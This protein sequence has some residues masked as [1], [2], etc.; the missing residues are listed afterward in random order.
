MRTKFVLTLFLLSIFLNPVLAATT[1]VNNTTKWAGTIPNQAKEPKSWVQLLDQLEE[2]KM[3]FSLLAAASRMLVLFNEL[4]VK[5]KAY[6]SI[7]SIIDMG[8]PFPL[9]NLFLSGDLSSTSDLDFNNSYSLYKSILNKDRGMSKWAQNYLDSITKKEE[10]PKYQFYLAIDLLSQK[11]YQEADEKLK[12][13]LK[14]DYE[15][16]NFSFVKK[17]TRTLARSY[18]DQE[19]YAESY[20]I[21][22]NYLL[23]LNPILPN[24]W[25]EAAWNLYYLKKYQ[26]ALGMVYNL[27]STSSLRN[28]MNL[29]KYTLRALIYRN[30]CAVQNAE[31]LIDTFQKDFGLIINGIKR[32]EP[33][34]KYSELIDLDVI[35]NQEYKQLSRTLAQLKAESTMYK[36]LPEEL[37]SLANYLFETEVRMIDQKIK[38]IRD[39]AFEVG[40]KKLIMMDENLRFLKFDV[41][42]E[43]YNPDLVF[44]PIFENDLNQPVLET[45]SDNYLIH[46]NQY[47]DFWRDE[48]LLMKGI[49]PNRCSE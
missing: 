38:G 31:T 44:K 49:L 29:E 12:A 39:R 21:Y 45:K 4:N 24:D 26:E 8:Y 41:Q 19:K 42:R 25:L 17:V 20:D 32:G 6:R 28:F 11:K 22:S 1:S 34:S 30:L 43:K 33:A 27:E 23:K 3:Q 36:I 10:F 13:I 15:P 46:W 9:Q 40:S 7:I 48:R 18:F 5:E 14:Q 2:K 37:H 35:E 16:K 47:G